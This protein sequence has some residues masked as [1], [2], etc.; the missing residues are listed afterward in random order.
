MQDESLKILETNAKDAPVKDVLWEGQTLETEPIKIVDP[1]VG[2]GVIVRNF[3]FKKNP[4][5][6]P[7]RKSEIISWYKKFIEQM[8]WK[9]GLSPI[10]ERIP[11]LYTKAELKKGALKT[12]MI[13]EGAD[14]VIMVLCQARLGVNIVD[15]FRKAV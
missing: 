8:L 4:A 15:N 3:F 9:D 11:Q 10:D 12:K 2:K 6:K 5:I 7:A 1:G 13:Q 14:F